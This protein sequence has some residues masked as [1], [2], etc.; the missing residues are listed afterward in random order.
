MRKPIRALL[1]A[2]LVL[3][4]AGAVPAAA[5]PWAERVE[6]M[7]RK[8]LSAE[9]ARQRAG[10]EEEQRR[11][12]LSLRRVKPQAENA[13]WDVDPSAIPYVLYQVRKRTSLPTYVNNDGLALTSDELYDHTVIYLT[14]HNDFSF[15][16]EEV[17]NLRR[18]LK[19]GGTIMFDDCYNRGSA[20]GDAVRPQMAK[21]LPGAT[22]EPLRRDDPRVEDVFRMAYT[23]HWP[24]RVSFENRTWSY[25]MLDGRPAVYFSPNDEGCA[26]EVS[27]PP[28]ASNPIGEPI[29]HGP[30]NRKREVYYQWATDWMLF[31]YTH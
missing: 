28:S 5:A 1:E 31:A 2:A 16:K 26:W 3:A 20:F 7:D 15:T 13:D 27:T 30:E 17:E 14:G 6:Q 23:K 12:R 10:A 18:W 22:P 9:E 19:R 24:G 21:V 29:G 4:L 8:A 11:N 25:Y